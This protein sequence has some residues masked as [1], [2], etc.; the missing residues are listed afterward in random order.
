MPGIKK[1]AWLKRLGKLRRQRKWHN[2]HREAHNATNREYRKTHPNAGRNQDP[3]VDRERRQEHYFRFERYFRLNGHV[4]EKRLQRFCKN[5]SPAVVN[6]LDLV[7][8][9]FIY[10]DANGNRQF[11]NWETADELVARL[12]VELGGGSFAGKLGINAALKGEIGPDQSKRKE[13]QMTTRTVMEWLRAG[14]RFPAG[15]G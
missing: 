3:N 6:Q 10:I 1:P 4:D 9:R 13:T 14:C 5:N 15:R 8:P 11:E 12:A 2:Q 7:S